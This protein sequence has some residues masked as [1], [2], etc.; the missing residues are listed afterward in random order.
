[1]LEV[2][3]FTTLDLSVQCFKVIVILEGVMCSIFI[4]FFIPYG[5]FSL[6]ISTVYSFV[7]KI[8]TFIEISRKEALVPDGLPWCNILD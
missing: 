6:I 7:S 5:F 1:M 4:S 3:A 2:V 8:I